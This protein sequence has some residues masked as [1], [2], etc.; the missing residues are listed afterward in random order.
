MRLFS[1]DFLNI[2][3]D[4]GCCGVVTLSPWTLRTRVSK[5]FKSKN[6]NF[7]GLRP[8]LFWL[9]WTIKKEKKTIIWSGFKVV[10]VRLVVLDDNI[11]TAVV[12]P[13]STWFIGPWEPREMRT[14]AT[15]NTLKFV[16]ERQTK[17]VHRIYTIV[18]QSRRWTAVRSLGFWSAMTGFNYNLKSNE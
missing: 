8:F 2:L 4:R 3:S 17:G 1:K 10:R 6:E 16:F 11:Y 12:I 14:R 13:L 18:T 15:K 5:V 9:Y 7:W